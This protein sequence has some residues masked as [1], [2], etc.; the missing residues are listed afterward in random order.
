MGAVG[1]EIGSRQP[2]HVRLYAPVMIG[3]VP[4]ATQPS[5]T[6]RRAGARVGLSL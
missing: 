1:A 3:R 5:A 6:R 2:A 4:S